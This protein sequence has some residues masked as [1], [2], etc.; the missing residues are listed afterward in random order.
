MSGLVDGFHLLVCDLDGV[1]VAGPAAVPHAVD[2]VN[3]LG[4]PVVFATNNASR[5]RSEVAAMLRGHGVRATDDRILTSSVVT[6]TAVAAA[7]PHGAPV[8]AI[9]GPGVADS[10][11]DAGLVVRSPQDE[12]GVAAVV[13]GYGPQ[14]CAADLGA[15]ALAIQSG[16][17]WFATNT[18]RTLPTDRGPMPGNGS[19]VAAVRAAVDVDPVVIGKPHPPMYTMAADLV[20]VSPERT[21][22][23]GDRLETDIAGARAAGMAAALVLSGVHGPADAAAAPPEHRPTHVIEDL[24]GLSTPYPETHRQGDWFVRGAARARCEDTLDVEGGGIDGIRAALDAIW[25]AVD[26]GRITSADA[27][28][29]LANR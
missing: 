12:G 2:S 5:T 20:G 16:A 1:V 9:G 13:Q 7:V 11:R 22:G 15:A 6:A 24:Q 23:V 14:V 25:A 18:D 26:A 4:I 8:M 10:L 28:A 19:L 27:R 21:L 3:A 17:S 29:L